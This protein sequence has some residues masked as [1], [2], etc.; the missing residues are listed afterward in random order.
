MHRLKNAVAAATALAALFGTVSDANVGAAP[1]VTA[2]Y[3]DLGA[4]VSVGFQPTLAAPHGQRTDHGYANYLVALE[5]AKGVALQLTQLG[6]PGESTED[7]LNGNGSCYQSPSTQQLA[8]AV[9]FLR[10]HRGERGLVTVDF[11]FND[12]VS[13]LKKGGEPACMGPKIAAVRR[14]LPQILNILKSVAG[15]QV[16]FIGVGHYDPFL[17]YARSGA[18]KKAAASLSAIKRLNRVLSDAYKAHAMPMADVA[19]AFKIEDRDGAAAA[20]AMTW[21]CQPP[22]LGPNLHPND[23]GYMTIAKAIAAKIPATW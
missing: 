7:M 18:D 4:S 2:F 6:C 13:C 3:L 11:G 5:A 19:R 15:P 22:P 17:A 20:C 8:Q 16:R 10:A 14:D 21:M 23:V 1:P 12:V 9:S